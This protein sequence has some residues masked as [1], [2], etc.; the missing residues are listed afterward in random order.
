MNDLQDLLKDLRD[1]HEPEA[2]SAWPPALGWWL[3]PIV[4]VVMAYLFYR[5]WKKS[6]I[7]NYKKLALQDFKN[8]KNN[9]E[10]SKNSQGVPG[11]IALLIRKAMVAKYGNQ[12]IAGLVGD[13]WLLRLDTISKTDSFT[14]GVGQ[15]LLTAPYQKQSEVDI[16]A[17]LEA[18]RKLLSRM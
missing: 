5:W 10:I 8:I 9:Y 15:C 17:L 3:L 13:E 14:Q 2:I 4:V 1:I 7:P 16:N 11:E 18:T 12:E 6:K